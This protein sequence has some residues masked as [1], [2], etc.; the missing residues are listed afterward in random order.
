MWAGFF[1]RQ[2]V[3]ISIFS[4]TK[5]FSEVRGTSLM[6]NFG[7]R[8]RFLDVIY[9]VCPPNGSPDPQLILL[10]LYLS[11]KFV[12]FKVNVFFQLFEGPA[13]Y[14]KLIN[15]GNVISSTFKLHFFICY[16][17]CSVRRKYCKLRLNLIST[18][19]D[20]RGYVKLLYC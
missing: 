11:G 2:D 10:S 17:F 16:Q 12:K 5:E 14:P 1:C 6:C 15:R 3:S 9:G 4:R 20:D 8:S 19:F 18:Q 7:V 13:V